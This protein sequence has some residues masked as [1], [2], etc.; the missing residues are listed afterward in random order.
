MP[1][2]QIDDPD[3]PRLDDFRDIRDRDARGPDGRPGVFIG[4]QGLVVEKML[5]RPGIVRRILVSEHRRGWLD[6]ALAAA[7]RPDVDALVA[8]KSILQEIVGFEIHRGIVASGDRRPFDDRTLDETIP[9]RDRPATVLVCESIRNIDNIG[10]LFR[11]AAAFGVDAVVLSP[12][13]H[14]PLYRKSLRVSIGHAL[15]IPFA[16]SRDW[17]A[18]LDAL[19]DRHGLHRIGASVTEGSIRADAVP[20]DDRR[21]RVAI[22]VGSEFDGLSAV[23]TAAC[24]ALVRIAMAR[25]VDSLNVAVAAA[26]L[27]DRFSAAERI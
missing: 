19:G 20:A 13:C 26:V 6:D 1:V 16:R 7:G 8:P 23:S 14:D 18:D 21:H 10:S 5:E 11:V 2:H 24:D 17:R 25:G 27:L 15:S 9:P 3:D 12:D 22:V 4:E